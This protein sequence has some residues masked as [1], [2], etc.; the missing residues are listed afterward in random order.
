MTEVISY[1]FKKK[2]PNLRYDLEEKNEGWGL[3]I[4]YIEDLKR[5]CN[6]SIQES[7][8][9]LDSCNEDNIIANKKVAIENIGDIIK[10][11]KWNDDMEF[12]KHSVCKESSSDDDCYSPESG[13]VFNFNKYSI[14]EN[15][16]YSTNANAKRQKI[17]DNFINS[18]TA[19]GNYEIK[20]ENKENVF[21]NFYKK[22]EKKNI[23]RSFHKEYDFKNNTSKLLS[24]S[25]N[26]TDDKINDNYSY[27]QDRKDQ[28]YY[29]F[30]GNNENFKKNKFL[31]NKYRQNGNNNAKNKRAKMLNL[32]NGEVISRNVY[33]NM[34]EDS[35]NDISEDEVLD[36]QQR[37]FIKR[38]NKYEEYTR[39]VNNINKNNIYNRGH[40]NPG[41]KKKQVDKKQKKNLEIDG[42]YAYN[43]AYLNKKD[44]SS[45]SSPL[46]AVND[47]IMNLEEEINNYK[48]GNSM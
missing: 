16:I 42:S 13:S 7:E 47:T 48:F 14:I 35:N 10:F 21:E 36:K 32:N 34:S 6:F 20:E 3:F 33:S 39:R 30:H 29:N 24:N 17:K 37:V 44:G 12:D 46:E 11:K 22:R 41:R 45:T 43:Y 23:F 18:Y 8:C 25:E 5:I 4:K 27:V 40:I 28:E 2:P 15:N 9:V 31:K 19:N 1:R 26:S 38:N